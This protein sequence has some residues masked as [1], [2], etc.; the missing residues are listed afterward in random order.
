MIELKI[1]HQTI[2]VPDGRTVLEA[3]REYGIYIPT[4]CYHPALEPYGAC[5]LCMVEVA[6][7]GRK[8]RL[9]TACTYPCES[10]LEVQTDCE[11]VRQSRRLTA[12]LL[13]AGGADT[14]EIADLARQLG[15]DTVR[16]HLPEA[17]ACVLCG[18]CVRACQEIVGVSALGMI[19]RGIA[20]QVSPPFEVASAVCIGCGTCVLICPTDALRLAEIS[21]YSS[22][23]LAPHEDNATLDCRLCSQEVRMGT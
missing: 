7:P 19:Q 8:P 5:R 13:M 12:E 22:P 1:N 2:K 20:K 17:G 16:Y 4:L 14:P 15:V 10:G 11:S 9:V 21:A 3:C 18:L 6:Q 23:H